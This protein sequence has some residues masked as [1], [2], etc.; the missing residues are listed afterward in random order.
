MATKKEQKQLRI[1]RL[2]TTFYKCFGS[3]I[4][5]DL[6]SN[7][8]RA[9]SFLLFYRNSSGRWSELKPA[10]PNLMQCFENFKK[11]LRK[12]DLKEFVSDKSLNALSDDRYGYNSKGLDI[13]NLAISNKAIIYSGSKE[14]YC[15]AIRNII[16]ILSYLIRF[17]R[18]LL[19][20]LFDKGCDKFVRLILDNHSHFL[21]KKVLL[22][23][24]DKVTTDKTRKQILSKI[25]TTNRSAV[26][27]W[28]NSK[29]GLPNLTKGLRN[30]IVYDLGFQSSEFKSSVEKSSLSIEDR[31]LIKEF[32]ESS[33]NV[34]K[35]MLKLS[36]SIDKKDSVFNNILFEVFEKMDDF[37]SLFDKIMTKD[38][39]VFAEACEH[40][41]VSFSFSNEFNFSEYDA[42]NLIESIMYL[43]KK[44]SLF[45]VGRYSTINDFFSNKYSLYRR[46]HW[47]GAVLRTSESQFGNL[48][49][50]SS[51]KL[52]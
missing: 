51:S 14:E 49:L 6:K 5:E 2:F 41:I 12:E 47:K 34:A 24:L 10:N 23:K 48:L 15:Y 26:I 7:Q 11:S 16:S 31:E 29:G 32:S 42:I 50:A 43:P 1:K 20:F 38:K 33:K 22:K 28:V 40:A 30:H 35:S 21:T 9:P 13:N 4:I 45:Y 27:S 8:W 44:F 17:D 36:K 19:N 46:Q 52:F 37:N 25:K 3:Q 18:N 39:A